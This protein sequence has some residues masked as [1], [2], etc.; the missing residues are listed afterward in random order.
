[1]LE[2]QLAGI[3]CLFLLAVVAEF[4]H[5]LTLLTSSL[6]ISIDYLLVI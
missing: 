5:L 1:M 6:E 3:S 4:G 2:N